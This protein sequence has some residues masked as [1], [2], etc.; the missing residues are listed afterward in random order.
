MNWNFGQVYQRI[1]KEKG[2]SQ[3]NVCG[4]LISRTTLSKIE[5][6]HS[7]PSYE[8]FAY[9]LKQ[10][11]MS[12]E[13]FE[14]VCNDF[15][16]DGRMKIFSKFDMAISNENIQTLSELRKDCINFLEKNH[17]LG[18]SDLLM[19]ID[20]LILIHKDTEIENTKATK[21]INVLWKKLELI[22]TWYYNEIKMI[23]CILFYFPIETVLSFSVKLIESIKKYEGF[24]KDIDNFCCAVYTNLATLYLYKN[25]YIECLEISKLIIE[26]AQSIKRYD[27][28]C[29]GNVRIGLC[30]KDKQKI[31]NSIKTLEFFSEIELVKEIKKEVKRFF[32]LING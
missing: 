21:L 8:T 15:E 19:T 1:R 18:I 13:E 23:N 16:L 12:F 11:N 32:P 25:F 20:Y 14:F 2:L 24:S 10:V 6:C 28:Y 27:V 5:N 9:L 7:V 3:K 22:D 17:D 29:L 30:M 31:Q 26:L 4:D